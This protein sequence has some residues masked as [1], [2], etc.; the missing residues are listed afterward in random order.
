MPRR[1]PYPL[2]PA[3]LAGLIPVALGACTPDAP[4]A[5]ARADEAAPARSP[6]AAV[7]A[8]ALDPLADPRAEVEASMRK[9]IAAG[10]YHASMHVDGGADGSM[11]SE[12]DFVAPDR[13]RLTMPRLGTQVIIGDTMYM[14]MQGRAMKV[15][16][17]EGTLGQWRDPARLEENRAETSVRA[18]GR[19]AVD[20]RPARKYAVH[21]ARPE[22]VDVTMWIGDDDLPLQIRVAGT[23]QGHGATTT[24]RYSR[25]DDP[26][27]R[28]TPPQ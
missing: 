23:S 26:T 10:S 17:P 24:I 25:F 3:L 9:F 27:I 14:A 21:H 15:P 20:G 18:L 16:L 5:P 8:A 7:A 11:T 13:Y 12:L 22:P 4:Q 19:E 1:P 6:A 28:I 2:A